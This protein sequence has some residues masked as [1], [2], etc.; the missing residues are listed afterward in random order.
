MGYDYHVEVISAILDKVSKDSKK[1]FTGGCEYF[2]QEK[3]P[4]QR[5]GPSL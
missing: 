1:G 3:F 2:N 5:E 4:L